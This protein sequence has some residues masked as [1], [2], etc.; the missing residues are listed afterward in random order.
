MQISRCFLH[1]DELLT[2]LSERVLLYFNFYLFY[3]DTKN[4]QLAPLES[5]RVEPR[6]QSLNIPTKI[7]TLTQIKKVKFN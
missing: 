6:R 1:N 4:I 2:A 5:S 7:S 3:L